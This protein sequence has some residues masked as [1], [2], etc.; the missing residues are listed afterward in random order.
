MKRKKTIVPASRAKAEKPDIRVWIRHGAT[1]GFAKASIR[2]KA[3]VYNYLV[4]RDGERVHSFYLGK[5]RKV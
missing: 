1:K 2:I 5:K 3:G 4:W